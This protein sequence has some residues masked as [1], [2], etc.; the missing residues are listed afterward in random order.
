MNTRTAVW[1]TLF[2]A[3][4]ILFAGDGLGFVVTG[5]ITLYKHRIPGDYLWKT[6]PYFRTPCNFAITV[7]C[8]MVLISSWGFYALGTGKAWMLYLY[9]ALQ[10]LVFVLGIAASTVLIYTGSLTGQTLA[11]NLQTSMRDS[12]SD[13]NIRDHWNTFQR[14]EKCCGIDDY[15]DWF[16]VA[17]SAPPESCYK[18]INGVTV[19][20]LVHPDGCDQKIMQYIEKDIR[21]LAVNVCVSTVLFILWLIVSVCYIHCVKLHKEPGRNKKPWPQLQPLP[22]RFFKH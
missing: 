18:V 2:I 11:Q 8:L 6:L 15:E 1:T 7:G 3:L 12:R 19:R 10:F 13:D 14:A 16:N 9:N 22:R 20:D 17:S 4:N 5:V 21:D